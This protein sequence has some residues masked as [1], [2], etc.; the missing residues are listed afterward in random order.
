[1]TH[2]HIR[3]LTTL[4]T[5]T[6]LTLL[7][8]LTCLGGCAEGEALR[9]RAS[10]IRTEL[11]RA[12][13]PAYRCEEDALARAH[14]NLT[15]MD[16]DLHQGD[17]FRAA[18]HFDLAE[19]FGRQAISAADRRECQD[20]TDRDG[21]P[22]PVDRCPR[23][24]EDFDNYEDQDGCPEDQDTD[25]DRILDSKDLCPTQPEDYDGVDDQDGCPDLNLDQDGDG[26]LDAQDQCPR[27]PEDKDNF[28]D[29]DGCPDL[30]NDQD[31]VLDV[32]DQCPLEPE[33]RD[34]F[35]DEDGCP[36]PDNDLDRILDAQDQC[37]LEPEDYDGD[38]DQDGCPD[39]YKRIVMHAD[40]IELRQ[41]V[42]F[43]TNEDRILEK[44]FELL[45]EVA[46]ALLD[47]P[48]ISVSIEGHTDNQGP[49]DYNQ[50]L[51]VRRAASVRRY[52][53]AQGVEAERMTSTGY[54]ESRPID[55]NRTETG[56]AANRRVE[57]LIT[58]R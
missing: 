53:I 47:Y 50:D 26:I 24:P 15:F 30:D 25:G 37:P 29:E 8:A 12:H 54:G 4:A 46:R 2:R 17:Y 21:I 42:Y 10:S 14:S 33:D 34:A 35:E 3:A 39:L 41:M 16:N 9:A 45:D 44:S 31:G 43:A 57:F 55:D 58:K 48:S 52:L 51:S 27:Q 56:R 49:D 36:D 23:E 7:T 11:D 28:Q 6:T 40:R 38:E 18:E 32:T 22:D 13:N 1:M 19:R 20:D 5:L